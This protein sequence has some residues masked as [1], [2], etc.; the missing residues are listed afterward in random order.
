MSKN[1]KKRLITSVILFL[2]LFAMLINNFILGYFLIITGVFAILEFNNIINIIYN[3]KKFNVFFNNLIFL[4]YIFF[5]C[6]AFLILSSFLY[7]KLII[8]IVLITC[9]TSDIGGFIFGKFFK[10]PRL[11]KLSPGKTISGALGSL[12]LSS[13]F[14]LLAIYYL[15]NNIEY[16]YIIVGCVISICSQIGDLF[17]SFLKRKSSLKD[18]GNYLPGHG[19]ILDRVDGIL[20]GLP[21]GFITLLIILT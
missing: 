19:G 18:T 11:T 13:I 17:F 14:M 10:G 6:A 8:F 21:V 20:L 5:F 4:L 2:I 7:L 9:V 15:T 16:Y 3:K 1:F 12:I